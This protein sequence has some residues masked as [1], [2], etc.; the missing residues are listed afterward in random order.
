MAK[1]RLK[2]NSIK[3]KAQRLINGALIGDKKLAENMAEVVREEIRKGVD[4]DLTSATISRRKSLATSNKTAKDYSASKSN[5]TFTGQFLESFK[6]KFRKTKLSILYVVEPRGVHKAYKLPKNKK[7][8]GK[9]KR[10]KGTTNLKIAEYQLDLGRNYKEVA[11]R[12]KNKVSAL[13]QKALDK[14]FR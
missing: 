9:R 3:R 10:L 7:K 1:V 2:K 13:I 6:G 14:Q 4:P 11:L 8:K 12:V 5:L